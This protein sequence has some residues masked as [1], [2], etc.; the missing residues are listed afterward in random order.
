MLVLDRRTDSQKFELLL[1]LPLEPLRLLL[2]VL[3]THHIIFV[4]LRVLLSNHGRLRRQ[5]P[6]EED[7]WKRKVSNCRS[8]VRS[9]LHTINVDIGTSPG[10]DSYTIKPRCTNGNTNDATNLC[11]WISGDTE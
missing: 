4:H 5:R 7:E 1:L 11:W 8:R 2:T 3:S 9:G 6:E 10:A